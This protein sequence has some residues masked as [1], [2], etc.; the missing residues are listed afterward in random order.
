MEWDVEKLLLAAAEA[1]HERVGTSKGMVWC[2]DVIQKSFMRRRM[3]P[4][5]AYQT[6]EKSCD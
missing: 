5:W 1:L 6:T 4:G 2:M 3:T